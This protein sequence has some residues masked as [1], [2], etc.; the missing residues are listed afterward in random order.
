MLTLT[1][2]LCF[3][4]V[5]DGFSPLLIQRKPSLI[6]LHASPPSFSAD[7]T[8][9]DKH[10]ADAIASSSSSAPNYIGDSIANNPLTNA[11]KVDANAVTSIPTL[12][13]PPDL[14]LPEFDIS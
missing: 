13:S 2:L 4:S 8:D 5:S 9:L 7:F 12:P 14:K 11:D 1:L 6:P 10:A 3:S